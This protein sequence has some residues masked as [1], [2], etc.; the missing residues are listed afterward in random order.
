MTPGGRVRSASIAPT[1]PVASPLVDSGLVIS[2]LDV[3][4]G[5]RT[6][7]DG[8]H[9]D[10]RPGEVVA[11][12]GESGSGKSSLLAA[13]LGFAES[14]GDGDASTVAPLEPGDR[15]SIAWAGQ[16]PS[17]LAGTIAE[18][19][20]LGDEDADPTG[21]RPCARPRRR[22][23]RPRHPRSGRAAAASRAVRRSAWPPRAR[24][25]DCS[26]GTA[27]SSSSTSRARRRTRDREAVLGERLRELAA[28]GR[29]VLVTTHRSGL[30]AAADRSIGA[31]GGACLIRHARCSRARCPG[32]RGSRRRS[33]SASPR[34]ARAS[35]CSR[36]PRGSSPARPSSRPCSTSRSA[37]SA[38]GP[39]R[40]GGRR[41]AT[42]SGSPATMRR[43]ASS[44]P[45]ARASSN[46]CCRSHP[47]AS[48]RAVAAT[49]SRG[50]SATSTSCRTCRCASCSRS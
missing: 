22:R 41:S 18:N 42:S 8:F 33:C 38:C 11:V 28:D 2:D 50:S 48:P 17:L 4:R 49:C 31:G 5:T 19:V 36:A 3:R 46:G 20:R 21:A 10:A 32:S 47:T 12:T 25:T 39:S 14:E 7:L 34:P 9:L 16:A 27:A 13:L 35:R 6:V 44:R 43:S 37:S 45:S 40:S 29:V 30:A 26:P 24:S 23:A 1:A 15:S